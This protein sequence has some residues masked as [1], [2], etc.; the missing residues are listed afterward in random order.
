MTR[1]QDLLNKQKLIKAIE[2]A[3]KK[4]AKECADHSVIATSYMDGIFEIIESHSEQQS[5]YGEDYICTVTQDD[6]IWLGHNVIHRVETVE[7]MNTAIAEIIAN[8]LNKHQQPDTVIIAGREVDWE[9]AL[10][11]MDDEIREAVASYETITSNQEF[12][13]EYAKQHYYDFK[14]VFEIN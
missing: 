1:T 2:E 10:R 7:Q 13:D 5:Q 8:N 12:V 4:T 6:V 3:V 14:E 9:V 11:Y